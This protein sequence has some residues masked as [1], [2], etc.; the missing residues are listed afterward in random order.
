MCNCLC[1]TADSCSRTSDQERSILD[2]ALRNV[3]SHATAAPSRSDR[4]TGAAGILPG[5]AVNPEEVTGMLC[6]PLPGSVV[7]SCRRRLRFG[8]T[9]KSCGAPS[10]MG[11]QPTV[12]R[13]V[14]FEL[15]WWGPAGGMRASTAAAGERPEG[16]GSM[17]EARACNASSA[18][19]PISSPKPRF[20][21]ICAY[22][23]QMD[24]FIEVC[25]G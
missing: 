25:R 21:S 19:G 7:L 18:V 24:H 13:S 22:G 2:D 1:N 12:I 16:R 20:S 15:I 3:G 9:S 6:T 17:P 14:K 10:Y 8:D 4:S 5:W 11:L 23:S